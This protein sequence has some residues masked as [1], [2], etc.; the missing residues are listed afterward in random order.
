MPDTKKIRVL[1]FLPKGEGGYLMVP[2][3]AAGFQQ[4]QEQ[5]AEGEPGDVWEVELA[6]MTE[7]ELKALSEH[8]GW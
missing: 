8:E 2:F 7:A 5:M 4:L 1:A 6:E 3:N